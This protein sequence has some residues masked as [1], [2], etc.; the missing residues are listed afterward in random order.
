MNAQTIRRM[1]FVLAGAVCAPAA[2]LAAEQAYPT[3]P[4]RLLVPFAP[5]GGA[6]LIARLVAPRLSERFAQPVVVDNRP[7]ASGTLATELAARATPDGHTLLV[8]TSN[9]IANPSLYKLSYDTI[10]DFTPITLAVV[11]PLV[12]VVHPSLP[13]NTVQEFIAYA[14]ANPDKLNYGAAGAGGPPHLAGELLKSMAGIKMTPIMYKGIGPAVIA[15]LGNEVQVT[16]VNIFVI[17]PHV[18][19]GRLRALGITGLKRSQA[20]PDWPTIAESGLP[21][22]EASIWFGFLAPA[23][24]PKPIIARLHREITS[25]LQLPEAQQTIVA[26]GGDPVAST[27]GEFDRV[28][29]DDIERIA[30]LVKTAGIRAD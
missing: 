13:V 4:I 3:K 6:D 28:I 11:S 7:T 18:R 26:Q 10:N 30:K 17:Q 22:Y 24:T 15:A 16:F 19:G 1:A 25:I 27:P 20:A 2:S 8:P 14:K 21:G 9:H 5:G 23:K 29:R 12:M